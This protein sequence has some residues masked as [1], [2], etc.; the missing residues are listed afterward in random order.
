M[1]RTHLASCSALAFALLALAP[2]CSSNGAHATGGAGGT[3]SASSTTG[4]GGGSGGDAYAA[5]VKAASWQ[6]LP[7]GPM[8]TGG[9]KQDDIFLLDASH[10]FVASGPSSAI[11]STTDGGKT[12]SPVFMHAG[13]YFRSI[14]FTDPQH[15]FAGNIGA[16]LSPTISDA[17]LLYATK[18]GGKTWAP[19][20]TIT[21]TGAEG[22]CNFFAVDAMHLFAVGRANGPAALLQSSDGGATWTAKSLSSSFS[23][24][25]D[26]HFFSATEG[27]L[28]GMDPAASHC[29]IQ[30][31]TDGGATFTPV[32]T[33]KTLGSLC[34]KLHFP[35]SLVGYAAVQDNAAGP[36]TFAKTTDGGKT[37]TEL[38]LPTSL[39]M[40]NA[41]YSA[42]G[43]GFIT[44]DIGWMAAED[45]SL[46]AY[47]TFDGGM[48]WE[49]DPTLK[50]PVNR[51]RFVDAH[52]AYAV[53]A[54][55]WKLV[56]PG[57]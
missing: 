36:G 37:W 48:T 42:I 53:G 33:S 57:Q 38:P 40:P 9:A 55:V 16:G 41:A 7:S 3:S 47:R 11:F 29:T 1:K 43:V 46:P 26:A 4:T 34:W 39:G 14:L 30:R 25:I 35:T 28:A 2:G 50:S 21:G 56:V 15:G 27:L 13:T 10:G 23:M 19:V 51:F 32:F 49:V 18:D 31:T 12:W 17:T 45:A 44:A 6:I 22:V 5:A 8:A 20:T 24:I 52:T 54:A